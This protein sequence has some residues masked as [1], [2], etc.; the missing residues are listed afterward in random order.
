MLTPII[1]HAGA[2]IQPHDLWSAWNADPLLLAGLGIVAVSFARGRRPARPA[3]PVAR[4][5]AW[6]VAG[7]LAAIAIALL[8]P[9]DAA[10][11]SLASAHMVQ[12]IA[13]ILIAAPLLV[14][15]APGAAI[16]RGAPALTRRALARWRGPLRSLRRVSLAIGT[17]VT[18]WLIHVGVLWFWHAATPYDTAVQNDVVHAAEHLTLTITAIIFWRAVLSPFGTLRARNGIG[19]LLVFA[20]G[21]QSVFLS[22]LLTFATTPWYAAYAE[23]TEAWGLT[24]LEDQQLAGAIMWV[25][26]GFAYAGVGLALVLTWIRWTERSP[27]GLTG[28]RDR[29]R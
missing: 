26:A 20:M 4:R 9:L 22:A 11:R 5:R 25:P 21:L 14:L 10:S 29:E 19:I 8:S 28:F 7:G 3:A 24:R 27:I 13:L 6:C 17:P 1:G 12:H 23:T 15:G 18:A 2:P 16:L